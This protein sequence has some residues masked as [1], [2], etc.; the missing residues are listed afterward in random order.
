[1]ESDGSNE[2]KL[3]KREINNLHLS[4]TD[5]VK[6]VTD[7]ILLD[8]H[9]TGTS[10]LKQIKITLKKNSSE[11]AKCTE[12]DSRCHLLF[13]KLLEWFQNSPVNVSELQKKKREIN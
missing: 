6:F 12:L 7:P 3:L 1:M 13:A 11:L 2:I 4:E 10:E 5:S 9:R 8:C